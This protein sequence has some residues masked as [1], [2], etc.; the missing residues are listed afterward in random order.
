M[1]TPPIPHV[2][3]LGGTAEARQLANFIHHHLGASVRLT[4]SLAGR[5]KRPAAVPGAVRVGGFG[6]VEGLGAYLDAEHVSFLIDATHPFAST[7]TRHAATAADSR[8]TFRLML[9]RAFWQIPAT[10]DVQYVP[11]MEAA[12]AA[13]GSIGAKRTL[14]TTGTQNLSVFAPMNDVWFLVRQIENHEKPL[15]LNN[16]ATFTQS[17]PFT[18]EGER[19]IM[20]ENRID[21]LVSK[22]SGGSATEAKLEAAAQLGI[23]TIVVRRPSVPPGDCVATPEEAL[24]WL[25]ARMPSS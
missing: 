24:A 11:D 13:L 5:T 4:T 25:L 10:L 19:A 15:P 22:E 14:L 16:A 21:T 12:A 2:L 8:K 7:I 6:G 9:V 1:T 17:P 20:L 23:K 3:V 18:L